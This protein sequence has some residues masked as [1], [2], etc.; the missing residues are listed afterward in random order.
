[1]TSFVEMHLKLQTVYILDAD[2][3][4]LTAIND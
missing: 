2:D 3:S 4:K 1:M